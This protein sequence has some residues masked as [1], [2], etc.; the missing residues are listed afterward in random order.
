MKYLIVVLILLFVTGTGC[1]P[2]GLTTQQEENRSYP[3]ILVSGSDHIAE[4]LSKKRYEDALQF[5]EKEPQ[6]LGDKILLLN[7]IA[8][9]YHQAKN[10]AKRDEVYK[11]MFT[12]VDLLAEKESEKAAAGEPDNFGIGDDRHGWMGA[13]LS[14]SYSH[15]IVK[16]RRDRGDIAGAVDLAQ[17]LFVTHVPNVQILYIA[18]GYAQDSDY[19]GAIEVGGAAAGE[20]GSD[21]GIKG[22]VAHAMFKH[23]KKAEAEK[24]LTETLREIDSGTTTL[25]RDFIV[26]LALCGRIDD[27]L[28]VSKT[29]PVVDLSEHR[30]PTDK[31]SKQPTLILRCLLMTDREK[32][33]MQLVEDWKVDSGK[34]LGIWTLLRWNLE[35]HLDKGTKSLFTEEWKKRWSDF[36]VRYMDTLEESDAILFMTECYRAAES[37]IGLGTDDAALKVL[38]K[39]LAVIE[40]YDPDIPD[41]VRS[42]SVDARKQVGKLLIR[43]RQRE[44][45]EIVFASAIKESSMY[46]KDYNTAIS[47]KYISID[48]TGALKD[49][50]ERIYSWSNYDK[51]YG[52]VIPLRELW[53]DYYLFSWYG[54]E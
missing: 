24:L 19:A 9:A 38:D 53:R 46:E 29:F 21:S 4:L 2:A 23:G 39:V 18:R 35:E 8:D 30:E 40:K 52:R 13:S 54:I 10:R 1:T 45:A 12:L 49:N 43:L 26:G 7:Q 25:H 37:L 42:G 17:K 34:A 50:P 28:R 20:Y 36:L 16:S 51:S 44:K 6:A 41:H 32:E 14:Q 15:S 27:A 5:V 48:H 33:A 31:H 11:K 22:Y 47:L 3:F